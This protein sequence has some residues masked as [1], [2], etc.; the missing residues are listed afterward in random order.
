MQA[1]ALPNPRG[2]VRS[3][4]QY[5]ETQPSYIGCMKAGPVVNDWKSPWYEPQAWKFGGSGA[6]G[7]E[8]FYMLHASANGY[9]LTRSV[10]M[11]IAH[12]GDILAVRN[13]LPPTIFLLRGIRSLCASSYQ[14]FSCLCTAKLFCACVWV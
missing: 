3:L 12:F 5:N 7:A 10:A 11:H 13:S 9:A 2:L 4:L 6:P 14:P 1:N 8:R